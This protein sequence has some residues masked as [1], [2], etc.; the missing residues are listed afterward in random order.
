MRQRK[1]FDWRI[2]G[3][4][5]PTIDTVMPYT[6]TC[7]EIVNQGQEKERR[8]SRRMEAGRDTLSML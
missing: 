7:D 5:K 1:I 8:C 4:K 3:M 6:G 2:D